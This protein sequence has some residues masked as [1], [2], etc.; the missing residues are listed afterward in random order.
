MEK[1]TILSRKIT[2]GTAH[3]NTLF[4]LQGTLAYDKRDFILCGNA[5][6]CDWSVAERENHQVCRLTMCPTTILDRSSYTVRSRG[7]RH[8]AP[9]TETDTDCLVGVVLR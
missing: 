2:D 7:H 6:H 8:R 4:C 9:H 1:I 3:E 5:K